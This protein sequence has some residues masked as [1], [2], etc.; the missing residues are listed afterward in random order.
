V[1]ALGVWLKDGSAGGRADVYELGARPTAGGAFGGA[2]GH[3]GGDGTVGLA[4]LGAMMVCGLADSGM[5]IGI[6]VY[7]RRPNLTGC[8]HV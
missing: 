3:Q 4:A 6:E 7:T 1:L 8:T 2:V 5:R